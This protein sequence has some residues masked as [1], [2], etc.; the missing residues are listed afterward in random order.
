MVKNDDGYVLCRPFTHSVVAPGMNLTEYVK[1]LNSKLQG[2]GLKVG[3][4]KM[5]DCHE[6]WYALVNSSPDAAAKIGSKFTPSQLE[7]FNKIV[8]TQPLVLV[9]ISLDVAQKTN[10]L[11]PSS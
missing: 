5:E 3:A 10:A 7:F 6:V 8:S 2:L 9:Y 4:A 1:K 11:D